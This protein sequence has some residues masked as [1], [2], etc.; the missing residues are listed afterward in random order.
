MK[1]HRP[2]RKEQADGY[3]G[4]NWHRWLKK[5]SNRDDRRYVKEMIKSGREDEIPDNLN[6]RYFGYE[7]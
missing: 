4:N 6:N 7:T 5:K 2:P 3:G 1:A